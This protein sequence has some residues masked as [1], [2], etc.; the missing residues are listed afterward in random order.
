MRGSRSHLEPNI[1]GGTGWDFRIDGWGKLHPVK[2]FRHCGACKR[3]QTP[4][5]LRPAPGYVTLGHPR[6]DTG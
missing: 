4:H 1:H 5:A 2:F 6:Y 3:S